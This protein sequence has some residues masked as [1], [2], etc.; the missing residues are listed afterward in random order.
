MNGKKCNVLSEP[1]IS[2]DLFSLCLQRTQ[3]LVILLIYS[4]ES[5][6]SL[7]AS[8]PSV[9]NKGS[10]GGLG[11][12]PCSEQ[13]CVAWPEPATGGRDPA[14]RARTAW[15]PKLV[16][17]SRGL[18]SDLSTGLPRGLF[19]MLFLWFVTDKNCIDS[20]HL[21]AVTFERAGDTSP[22]NFIYQYRSNRKTGMT[23]IHNT[24]GRS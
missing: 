13:R 8:A 15:E 3:V 2:L 11:P 14:P 24:A 23:S 4:N 1:T 5:S 17:A 10:R 12:G 22:Q 18:L 20:W 6:F 16:I 19:T 7:L 9:P 21:L